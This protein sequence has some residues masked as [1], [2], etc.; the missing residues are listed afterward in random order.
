VPH[1]RLLLILVFFAAADQS[2][3]QQFPWE[4]GS[5]SVDAL[6]FPPAF[7]DSVR[8]LNGVSVP[9]IPLRKLPRPGFAGGEKLVYDIGWGPFRAGYVISTADPD[10]AART[11]KLGGKAIS[12]GI[13]KNFFRIRDYVISTVDA[14]GLYPLFFEQHIREGKHYKL[15]A[16]TL[17]DH[18]KGMLCIQTKK[19]KDLAAPMFVNDFMSVFY[20]IRTRK[21]SPGD[22]FSLPI[23]VDPK[24]YSIFFEC[25]QRETVRLSGVDIPCLLVEPRF[26][27]DAGVFTK[28]D[29]LAVWLSDDDLK[30][31]IM[32]KSKVQ[33]GSAFATLVYRWQKERP[34]D[35]AVTP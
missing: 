26:V 2:P 7:I 13:V 10:T 19:R 20:L 27:G 17:F 23:F 11:I 21:I 29:R 6:A 34:G 1:T 12:S 16:W 30:T 15:D 14:D 4:E 25:R 8:L 22:T 18:S 3:A 28:K 24:V 32:I 9:E 5:K 35:S 33:V 31:P